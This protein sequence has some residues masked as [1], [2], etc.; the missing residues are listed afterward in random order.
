MVPPTGSATDV[1]ALKG[2]ARRAAEGVRDG[3]IAVSH[4]MHENP[5][6]AFEEHATSALLAR[7]LSD[8]G[9][10]VETG[11][12]GLPTALVATYGSGDLVVGFCAEMDALPGIGHACGHNII[13]A[14]GITAGIALASVADR[15]GVTVKVF[16]TPAEEFGGGKIIMLEHGAFDG[17]HAA[18][19]VHPGIHEWERHYARAVID[20]QVTYTGRTAHAAAAP[21]E[22][23]NAADAVTVAQVAIGLMRQQLRPGELVHGI[24]TH[25]G[26][27]PN[28]IPGSASMLYDARSRTLAGLGSVQERLRHCFEAGAVATGATMNIEEKSLPFGEFRN[29]DTMARL[30]RANAEALGRVFEDTPI[31]ERLAEAG[32]TDMGNVSLALPAIHPTI[33]VEAHGASNHQPE[34][35]RWCAQPDADRAVLE[36]GVA[37]AWTA[38]DLARDGA[39]RSRLLAAP[40]HTGA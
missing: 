16:G 20:L 14:A 10:T 37:M 9:F 30:Y 4:R 13:A 8:H 28:V 27:A 25:G 39:Q 33:R 2:E 1:S 29:D 31:D 15:L 12:A 24:V 21:Y 35:A 6:V 11:I 26:E 3:V 17:V 23:V 34:F 38:I 22:G 19:M 36:G 40:A 32:S 18:M 7:C 5:E